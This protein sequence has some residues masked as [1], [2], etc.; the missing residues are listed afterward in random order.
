MGDFFIL[1]VYL[2]IQSLNLYQYGLMDIRFML[3]VL[4]QSYFVAHVVVAMAT[5]SSFS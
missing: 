5:G 4:I 3:W 2:F 1:P